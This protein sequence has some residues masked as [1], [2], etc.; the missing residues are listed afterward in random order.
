MPEMYEVMLKLLSVYRHEFLNHLQVVGGM[1]QLNKTDRLMDF[2]RRASE[3]IQQFGRLAACGDPRLCLLIHEN[4]WRDPDID[5]QLEV[6]GRLT[7][8]SA[9]TISAL[10]DILAQFCNNL[11]LLGACKVVVT[12]AAGS[13]PCLYLRIDG[14]MDAKSFWATLEPLCQAPAFCIN[15]S[16]NMLTVY[17]DKES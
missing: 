4:F 10:E 15:R 8:L 3:E 16:K 11:Q 2:V 12:I 5:I 9:A 14:D 17:L 7:Q 1:A 13:I 6:R